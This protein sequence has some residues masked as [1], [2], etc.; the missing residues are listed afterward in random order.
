MWGY[1]TQGGRARGVAMLCFTLLGVCWLLH[2]GNSV[3][4][5]YAV[6][7]TVLSCITLLVLAALLLQMAITVASSPIHSVTP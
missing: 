2:G 6:T 1:R 3:T 4:G 7:A 5:R